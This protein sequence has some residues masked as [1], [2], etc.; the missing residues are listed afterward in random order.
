MTQI[1]MMKKME[2]QK[3][4]R[5]MPILFKYFFFQSRKPGESRVCNRHPS[6]IILKVANGHLRILI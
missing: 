2:L 4:N 6:V 1:R 5:Q 3:K